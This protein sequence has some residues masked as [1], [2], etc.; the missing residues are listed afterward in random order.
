MFPVLFEVFGIKIYTYGVLVA[1]GVFLAYFLLLRLGK[2]EGLNVNHIENTLLL[3]LIFGIV[4]SRITYIMEHPEQI[5]SIA[6]VFAIWQ[7][8]LT[9]FGG[10]I[11]GIVGV[12]IGTYKYKLPIWKIADLSVIA[13][14]IAHSIGRLGCTS[15]GCCYGKPFLAENINPGIHFSD[16]FPFF[17]VVFPE[18]AVAPPYMPLYP[19]QLMEFLGLLVIFFILLLFSKRKPFDGFLFAL[20]MLLYGALRFFLEFYR[21]VTPPIQPIGLTWNQIVSIFM[22]LSSLILMVVLKYERKAKK[23]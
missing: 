16:K 1:M 12:L 4:I 10:L 8:G 13:V 6:D 23:A 21:G 22:A 14:A 5:K 20:Y 2:K 18:G 11:G 7:G 9:F 17:Y 3:A 15:A 19:T